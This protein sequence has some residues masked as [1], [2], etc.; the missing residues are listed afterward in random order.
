VDIGFNDTLYTPLGTAR[1][2]SATPNFHTL[3][4][5]TGN[6]KSSPACTVF[7]SRFLVTDINSR[8]SSAC[9]TP[10]LLS[11]SPVQKTL[12]Q[13]S[14]ANYQLPLNH[15]TATSRDCLNYQ[16]CWP[17]GPRYTGSGRTQQKTPSLNNN[18]IVGRWL[19]AETCLP[20][21]SIATNERLTSS[22]PTKPPLL[23]TCMFRA[24]PSND[25]FSCSTVLALSK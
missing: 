20:N 25:C 2:Y 3:Q 18:L 19:V 13:L 14:P 1:N 5:T 15:L 23:R 4:I 7:N 8:D 9:R 22:F 12:Y 24:L 16:F 6:T 11:Q 17:G 21:C 10:S